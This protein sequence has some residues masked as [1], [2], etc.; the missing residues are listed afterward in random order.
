MTRAEFLRFNRRKATTGSA[1]YGR[2]TRFWS[3][4]NANFWLGPLALLC[5]SQLNC[6]R[7][8][9]KQ[10]RGRRRR[11]WGRHCQGR[12]RRG[13]ARCGSET[14]GKERGRRREGDNEDRQSGISHQPNISHLA[15]Y[16]I[17]TVKFPRFEI[18]PRARQIDG[19][20]FISRVFPPRLLRLGTSA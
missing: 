3:F 18:P 11:W 17:P 13:Q 14:K 5:G 1:A 8:T 15:Q 2:M 7:V 16:F 6:C 19:R 20:F 10:H 9:P 4:I 12:G